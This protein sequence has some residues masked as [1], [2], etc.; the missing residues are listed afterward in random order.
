MRSFVAIELPDAVKEALAQLA[1]RL[2][3]AR[4]PAS[5]VRPEQIHLTL[6]FLGDVDK[7]RLEQLSAALR[8]AY[9][10]TA[11]FTVRVRGTGGFPNIR[12]PNVIWVSLDPVENGL[13]GIQ[14]KAELA[15]RAIGLPPEERPFKPHLTLA[16]IKEPRAAWPLAAM[17]EQEAGFDAGEF[18]VSRVSLFSSQ[19]NPKGALHTRLEEFLF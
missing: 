12:R 4:V 13:G 18:T 2:R 14:Q 1:E 15:A 5:W 6:R 9:R 11:P 19:L 17:L 16:R 3:P 7:Q 8:A 10:G